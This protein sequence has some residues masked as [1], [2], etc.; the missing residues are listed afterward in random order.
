MNKDERKMRGMVCHRCMSNNTII[1]AKYKNCCEY[2]CRDC[3]WI[4][5]KKR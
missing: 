4:S 2:R 3:G 1:K 5:I